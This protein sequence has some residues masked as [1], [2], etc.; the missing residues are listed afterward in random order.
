MGIFEHPHR[1]PRVEA[2]AHHVAPDRLDHSLHLVSLEI[3]AVVLHRKLD[4][5][6]DDARAHAAHGLD[7]VV[8]V[9]LD[10]RALGIA[11][12]HAPHARCA[13][14]LRGLQSARHLF[15]ERAVLRVE[16]LRARTYRAER[17]LQLDAEPIGVRA[18]LAERRF[19]SERRRRQRDH[20][21]CQLQRGE[22]IEEPCRREV[23]AA[24]ASV[25]R[26]E[27]DGHRAVPRKPTRGV[28][29]RRGSGQHEVSPIHGARL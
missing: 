5:G 26:A 20:R 14:D 7:H 11:A 1:V 15:L 8:D 22:V 4:A 2:H 25:D 23:V 27:L 24:H 9:C 28:E 18:N 19:V 10:L 6:I 13:E 21:P 16:R 12:E 17:E 3:A 29:R